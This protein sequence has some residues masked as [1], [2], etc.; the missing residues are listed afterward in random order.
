MKRK[1]RWISVKMMLVIRP[2]L[3]GTELEWVSHPL[4]E[5]RSAR[6]GVNMRKQRQLALQDYRSERNRRKYCA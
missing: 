6:A 3:R 5:M 2:A 1:R 4:G